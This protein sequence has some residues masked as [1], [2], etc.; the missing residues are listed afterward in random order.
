MAT[1]RS[2]DGRSVRLMLAGHGRYALTLVECGQWIAGPYEITEHDVDA[3]VGGFVW[4]RECVSLSDGPRM[5]VRLGG[6]EW[7]S[8]PTIEWD[9]L[10][11]RL[12]SEDDALSD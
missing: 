11:D 2:P 9:R 7:V 5:T 6:E 3:M 12:M 4:E 1:L 8:F 10:I